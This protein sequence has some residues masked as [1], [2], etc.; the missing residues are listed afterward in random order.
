MS[1]KLVRPISESSRGL[2]AR[3]IRVNPERKKN[4]DT[5]SLFF[6]SPH[7]DL[8]ARLKLGLGARFDLH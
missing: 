4:S 3:D 6:I 7:N 5:R 8:Q 2:L 1:L